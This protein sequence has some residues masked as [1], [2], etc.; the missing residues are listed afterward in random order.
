MN[1]DEILR[2]LI[3][4]DSRND[5]EQ[6]LNTLRGAGFAVRPTLVEDEEDMIEA[7]KQHALDLVLCATGLEDFSIARACAAVTASG[8][9]LPLRRGR[10]CRDEKIEPLVGQV[11]R[12]FSPCSGR[13]RPRAG[14]SP[15]SR[16]E[17]NREPWANQDASQGPL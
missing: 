3:I 4:D 17:N 5:A 2:L 13:R 9:A 12:L 1:K 14:R 7:L 16:R 11:H 10:V 15:H 6:M 8:K